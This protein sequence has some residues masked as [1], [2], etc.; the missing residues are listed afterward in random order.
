[1]A[2]GLMASLPGL[3]LVAVL[4]AGHVGGEWNGRTLTTVMTAEG[5]RWRLLAAK[6][7]SVWLAA[8][9]TLAVMFAT[10]AAAS[11]VWR[12]VFPL[13]VHHPTA[14]EQW[15]RSWPILAHGMVTLAVFTLLAVT[16]AVL[17]KSIVGT[18]TL[19][20]GA[21]IVGL[22]TAGFPTATDW[23]LGTW[24][25]SWTRFST[26]GERR[27]QL[28]V[29]GRRFANQGRRRRPPAG[30]D[31]STALPRR[32]QRRM[33]GRRGAAAAPNGHRLI[34]HGPRGHCDREGEEKTRSSWRATGGATPAGSPR[35]VTSFTLALMRVRAGQP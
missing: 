21:V 5:R 23:T 1:M 15:S 13:P 2:A 18:L 34:D 11:P 9:A 22:A 30:L 10:L 4:A 17:T 25:A 24:V 20:L 31:Y 35:R 26:P 6:V 3:A 33:L 27:H 14:T 12:S 28:L 16:P 8:L 19:T 7:V 29:T 32:S